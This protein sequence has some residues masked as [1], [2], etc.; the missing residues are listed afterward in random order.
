[1]GRLGRTDQRQ[2]GPV[3]E[4]KLPRSRCSRNNAHNPKPPPNAI[5]AALFDH[6]VG[7]LQE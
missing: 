7:A 6:L 5:R 4:A 2:I 3:I 1:M